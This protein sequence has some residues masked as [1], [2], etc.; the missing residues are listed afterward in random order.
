MSQ[1]IQVEVASSVVHVIN[2]CLL[3]VSIQV[4]SSMKPT[5][6]LEKQKDLQPAEE[7]ELLLLRRSKGEAVAEEG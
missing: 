6:N 4:F 5:E 1:S 7:I 2:R 3:P